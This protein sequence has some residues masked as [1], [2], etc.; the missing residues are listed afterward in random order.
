MDLVRGILTKTSLFDLCAAF[1]IMAILFLRFLVADAYRTKVEELNLD[2]AIFH[3]CGWTSHSL[4]QNFIAKW[5][6]V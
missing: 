4:Q 2:I 5:R 1:A 3:W 6:K